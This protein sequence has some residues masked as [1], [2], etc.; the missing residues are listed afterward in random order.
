MG[1]H[2]LLR[3][4]RFAR[5]QRF[6]QQRVRVGN[7]LQIALTGMVAVSVDDEAARIDAD[8]SQHLEEQ[9]MLRARIDHTVK[10]QVQGDEIVRRASPA[11]VSHVPDQPTQS[12]EVGRRQMLHRQPRRQSLELGANVLD[13]DRVLEGDAGDERTA[14]RQAGQ[15]TLAL[16]GADR[17]AHWLSTHPKTS[18][19]IDFEDACARLQPTIDDLVA[20]RVGYI[21]AQ[22]AP[23]GQGDGRIDHSFDTA[24]PKLYTRLHLGGQARAALETWSTPYDLADDCIRRAARMAMTPTVMT[25]RGPVPAVQL[26]FTLIHEHLLLDLMRDAW[27]GNHIL[28]DPELATL[29]LQR[30]KDAGGVT[31]VD[32]TNRGLAQDPVAVKGIAGRTGV[33][34]ILGCGWYRETYYEPYLNRWKTDQVAD[35]MVADITEGI[36]GTGVRAGIIG[37]IGAHATWISPAEERVLRAAGRAHKRTGL[38]VALHATRGPHG[39]DQLDILREEGVDPHRVVVGHA[40]SYPVFE[41]HAEIARRGAF[42]SFDRMGAT[43]EYD[44]KNNLRLIRDVLE[45]GLIRNLV[46]SHDVCY[47]SDLAT[48]GGSGYAF[49]STELH[50]YFDEAGLSDAD[51]QQIMV[52]NPRRA[53]TGAD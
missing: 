50:H 29:E 22:C 32:Q 39:L 35:Q 53:L 30:Y 42:I 44:L 4:G 15:Q 2:S 18:G 36:D 33:H 28:N 34:V 38:T 7:E 21:V 9:P 11:G 27:I 31:L 52:D 47:R 17:F 48:Y 8:R 5:Q 37:E 24:S 23:A 12:L 25:V 20:E 13:G 1:V 41:Y 19:E 26:G 3:S 16:E 6:E 45:A 14:V 46:L 49:L 43:N 51:F 10:L 40:Q